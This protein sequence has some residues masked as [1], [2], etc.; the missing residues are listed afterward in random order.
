MS[1]EPTV[2]CAILATGQNVLFKKLNVESAPDIGIDTGYT[3]EDPVLMGAGPDPIFLSFAEMYRSRYLTVN[4]SQIVGICEIEPGT[5][6]HNAYDSHAK[7]GAEALE[8][9]IAMLKEIRE[10]AK[11]NES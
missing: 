7:S 5:S 11:E 3:L 4:T 10:A 6:V 1:K 2:L 9:E 8:M